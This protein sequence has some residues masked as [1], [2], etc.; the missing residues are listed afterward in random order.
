MHILNLTP[1]LGW[2]HRDSNGTPQSVYRV[3]VRNAPNGTG[4][5]YDFY[6]GTGNASSYPYQ[7]SGNGTNLTRGSVYYLRVRTGNPG[8]LS[9]WSEMRFRLNTPPTPPTNLDPVDG[10]VLPLNA[11]QRVRWAAAYDQQNDSLAY[12]WLVDTQRPPV[13]PFI[14]TGTTPGLISGPFS[15]L[16]NVTYYWF[17]RASDG[18]EASGWSNFAN[19]TDFTVFQPN[20]AP[21]VDGGNITPPAALHP[22]V[23]EEI[24]V[25]YDDPDGSADLVTVWLRVSTAAQNFSLRGFHGSAATGLGADIF[26]DGVRIAMYDRAPTASGARV[27]W[28]F[29]LDW[30]WVGLGPLSV[31]ARAMDR[32]AAMGPWVPGP[33]VPFDH[34][35]ATTFA[36]SKS[37]TMRVGESVTLNGTVGFPSV[38]RPIEYFQ[39]I[40]ARARLDS[41]TGPEVA[42]Q[43]LAD[44]NFS[45]TWGPKAAHIGTH[46]LYLVAQ[47]DSLAP[48]DSDVYWEKIDVKV[49]PG[50]PP[51]VLSTSP[52]EGSQDIPVEPVVRLVFTAEMNRT[53]TAAALSISPA[54]PGH[55]LQWTGHTL[56]IESLKLQQS[57]DYVLTIGTT[58]T[59]VNGTAMKTE[60]K[61]TFRTHGAPRDPILELV[62]LITR[63]PLIFLGLIAVF[64]G[65]IA[66]TALVSKRRRRDDDAEASA[67][68][69]PE[70][71]FNDGREEGPPRSSDE[72]AMSSVGP[73]VGP[74]PIDNGASRD[75]L[76]PGFPVP[77]T[78]KAEDGLIQPNERPTVSGG[79]SLPENLDK[80]KAPGGTDQ[81]AT[82][83][84]A[85]IAA[86][87][88]GTGGTALRNLV[89]G[90]NYILISGNPDAALRA[91][92]RAA[93]S[94][95][96]GM[97]V[98]HIAPVKLRR[99]FYLP[100]GVLVMWLTDMEDAPG[101]INPK[102][103]EFELAKAMLTFIREGQG[104]VLVIDCF[105]HLVQENGYERSFAT[106]KRVL[107]AASEAGASV[108]AVVNPRTLGDRL[109]DV[110]SAFDRVVK[111]E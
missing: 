4:F 77:V 103:M 84:V 89:P 72:G 31:E 93:L 87:G 43:A 12:E 18:Y 20:R 53:T 6:D 94:G 69:A 50:Q 32:Y 71:F 1:L 36:G 80:A 14:S 7:T 106:L 74:V 17:I 97:V 33:A 108:I 19:G 62:D 39:N 35:I 41:F 100:K 56:T 13:A 75:H 101:G 104:G 3:E 8:N 98:T 42:W 46:S 60:F 54:Y 29:L 76:S 52:E 2:E 67:S 91:A 96:R 10:A 40:S 25:S 90:N 78:A 51:S 55:V 99:Q 21:K 105:E 73:E 11:T 70:N 107:D 61:L 64:A 102:R 81:A 110:R 9:N 5:M 85:P 57:T 86:S 109:G 68:P 23:F 28:R 26:G 59:D 92:A 24:D 22:V 49:D 16:A 30:S 15:T 34:G 27:T 38:T 88:P 48:P 83:S 44:Q 82:Q 63:S 95:G 47:R 66:L 37:I 79:P 58:A 65:T 45:L 111:D